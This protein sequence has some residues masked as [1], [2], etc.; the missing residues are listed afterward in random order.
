[1]QVD[2]VTLLEKATPEQ[3]QMLINVLNT[4]IGNGVVD[5]ALETL[6]KRQLSGEIRNFL[7]SEEG[8][9]EVA[10]LV[11]RKLN[12]PFER[13]LDLLKGYTWRIGPMDEARA[14][15]EAEDMIRELKR[16]QP[17]RKR[18]YFARLPN[19]TELVATSIAELYQELRKAGLA[20]PSGRPGGI[21][22]SWPELERLT[23]TSVVLHNPNP[24]KK[25]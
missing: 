12:K 18:Q 14:K 5:Q 22:L 24:H 10:K 7:S 6:T 11:S 2:V 25:K 1:M 4:T 21:P 3:R 8:A 16:S 15:Q 17:E 9:Q 13:V 20:R 23:D 19:G